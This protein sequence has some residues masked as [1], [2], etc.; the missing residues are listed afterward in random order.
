MARVIAGSQVETAMGGTA[1]LI[2]ALDTRSFSSLWYWLMLTATWTWVTRG[3]L[4][5]PP[6]LVRSLQKRRGA[7]DEAAALRLLDW[8]SLVV[9]RWQLMRDDGAVLL[10]V[11]SFVLSMLAGLGFLYGLELAQALLLL[12]GPLMLLGWMRLRL[13]ARLRATLAEAEGGRLPVGEAASQ[14]A[15]RITAHMRATLA[16]SA[17]AVAVAAVWGTIWLAR[18]PNGL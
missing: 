11:A 6:E 16:L 17:A 3:A 8:V 5:I 13:A 15:A 18:H 4:G 10:G 14:I 12:I 1:G 2:E 9:P 7:S